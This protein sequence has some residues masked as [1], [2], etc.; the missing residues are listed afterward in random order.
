MPCS[1]GKIDYAT[2]K[3]YKSSLS[4][5]CPL[6]LLQLIDKQ[7]IDA[8]FPSRTDYILNLVLNNLLI[9]ELINDLVLQD[10]QTSIN[11]IPNYDKRWGYLQT[12]GQKTHD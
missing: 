4:F 1:K 3:N 9:H 12:Q 2:H 6:E 11:P 5:A 10:F 7:Y 8:S